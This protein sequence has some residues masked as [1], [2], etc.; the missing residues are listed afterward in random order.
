[1]SEEYTQ[2][3]IEAFAEDLKASKSATPKDVINDIRSLAD[4]HFGEGYE[5]TIE[6]FGLQFRKKVTL[7]TA[8]GS[9]TSASVTAT[10]NWPPDTDT[11]PPDT[12]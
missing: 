10:V 4:K 7:S 3:Q 1:M 6:P 11:D 12:D 2:Q 5:A 9:G 8:S